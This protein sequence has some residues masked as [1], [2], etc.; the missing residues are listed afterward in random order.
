MKKPI[1]I[2]IIIE[3]LIAALFWFIWWK[4][5]PAINIHA[6]EIW[7]FVF[8]FLFFTALNIM[9]W[10]SRG[11]GKTSF[12][13]NMKI[14]SEQRKTARRFKKGNAGSEEAG[15]K[16]G[17]FASL[18]QLPLPVWVIILAIICL[19][20]VPI[21]SDSKL[22]HA[23]AYSSILQVEEADATELPDAE[24]TNKIALMDTASAE[25]LGDREIGSLSDV[26]SQY[27]VTNYTQINYLGDPVKI[28]PL[29]YASFF[30]WFRN[31]QNGTPGYVTV[32][33][34]KMDAEYVKLENGMKYTPH[35]C[36]RKN[37]MRHLRYSYPTKIFW[38]Y[39]FEVDED[40]KAWFVAP[41]VTK[42]IGLFA[43]TVVTGAVITD[44]VTGDT[45]WYENDKIPAWVDYV[46]D[47]NLICTQYN[48]YGQ[49]S[50]GFWNSKLS[51]R[52]CRKV[53]ESSI[54]A[55]DGSYLSDYGFIAKDTDIWIYT[56]ITSVNGDS[57]N[58][59][60]IMSNQR[61]SET[62]YI[63]CAG[64]DEFSAMASA[65]G[66]V[67]EKRYEA[68]FPSLILL[69]G[70]PTYIMVLKDKSGLVKA[71]ACVNVEQYNKVAVAS[72]Q[73][74]CIQ[75]YKALVGG[76]LSAED[77]IDT[78]TAADAAVD[79][80]GIGS[81]AS[82]GTDSDG[83]AANG[84]ASSGSG[85]AAVDAPT[86]IDL[87][88]A[89]EKEIT[90]SKMETIDQNGN[91]WLYIVDSENNIYSAKYADVLNMLLVSEGDTITILTDGTYYQYP[92]SEGN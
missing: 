34:V 27:A 17:R 43:G 61:T 53:T 50:N 74:D 13:E 80:D 65:E 49:L 47:G 73:D 46:F 20:I 44:P 36:F 55:E 71:Y 68:S 63:P 29:D 58:I 5:L 64:A 92:A 90:V 51:Q 16:S 81:S 59:G 82:G 6:R 40:G 83:S 45:Q 18:K 72:T 69:D 84:S 66:E 35:A 23:N 2:H 57:S 54:S 75:K 9:A 15:A 38:G 24:L 8:A 26:V 67:Q 56:G 77:A 41:T 88:N 86:P 19:G 22:L 1:T 78:N 10:R 37:L 21:F 62:K 3:I 32:S 91:T 11:Y 85:Y 70:D 4:T 30:K 87:A 7:V 25:K 31:R 76:T 14:R 60:F 12:M 79:S 39:H 42:K 28:A 89:E 33:P 48:W 52:G